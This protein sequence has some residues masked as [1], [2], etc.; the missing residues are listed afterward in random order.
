MK[1]FLG[2]GIL[3][4]VGCAEPTTIV[5]SG[6][7][8]QESP[9]PPAPRVPIN[10]G[11]CEAGSD[12]GLAII[13]GTPLAASSAVA[14][15]VVKVIARVRNLRGES[16]E[17]RISLCTGSL[18][19][20]RTVLTA[21]HCVVDVRSAED[22]KLEFGAD[23][24]CAPEGEESSS[25]IMGVQ[26]FLIHRQYNTLNNANDLALIRLNSEAPSSTR[27][28]QIF[29]QPFTLPRGASPVLAVGFGKIT[30]AEDNGSPDPNKRLRYGWL[31]RL[32]SPPEKQMMSKFLSERSRQAL[33]TSGEL[34]S[35]FHIFDQT[36]ENGICLGDSGGPTF[37]KH[38]GQ[39]K[40][41]GVS[42]FIFRY[43]ETMEPCRGLSAHVNLNSYKN[44]L[45]EARQ[46][47]PITWGKASF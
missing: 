45:T 24:F 31:H 12:P 15:Q 13:N 43:R 39:W 47:L 9:L 33:P 44:W 8:E 7:I 1:F 30:R 11:V 37:V 41:V 46:V 34:D 26:G 22:L 6:V 38:Q 14:E 5:A 28:V 23:P 3:L 10:S 42:S 29:D 32:A 18:L 16:E 19:D 21:A 25:V 40:Q 27:P 36:N 20:S 35:L 17:Y 2:L 4:L